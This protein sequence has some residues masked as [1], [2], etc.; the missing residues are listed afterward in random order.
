MEQGFVHLHVHSEYSLL[1]GANR[2][3]RLVQRAKELGMPALALTDHGNLFGAIEFYKKAKEVGIKPILGMEAYLAPTSRK[4]KEKGTFH[5]TLLAEN[6]EGFRNLMYLSTMSYLEGFYNRPRIDKE[7]LAE[8]GEGLIVLSGCLTSELAS[9]IRR[10]M[11][12]EAEKAL[13]EYLDIFGRDRFYIEI[14]RVMEE[15]DPV[16]RVLLEFARKH[17]LKVVATNDVHYLTPEEQR[18]QDVLICIQTG[19]RLNDPGRMGSMPN[20]YLKSPQEMWALFGNEVPEALTNTLEI[21]ERVDLELTLDPR[22]VHLPRFDIPEAYESDSDYL[23]HLAQEG[24]RRRFPQGVPPEYW[25]RLEHELRVIR[26]MGYS[27]YFLIIW[28]IVRNAKEKRGIRVGPGRGS[29]VGSLVL[30]ALGVTEIDPIR[31]GLLFERFLNPERVSPP[32]VDIDFS[33]V[34]RDKVIQYVRK[35]FGEDSVSQIITFGRMMARAVVRDVGRVLGIP[36]GETDRLVRLIP[37]V[38]GMTLEQ[39]LAE[40]RTLREL[41]ETTYA[42]L[43]ELARRIEGFVR[44]VSTHAAGVVIAPGKIWE[45]V[46]LY[47]SPDGTVSTQFDMKSLED[48]GLLKMD[49]LGLRTL[50]ILQKAEEMVRDRHDPTFS[51]SQIPLD[52]PQT[53]ALIGRGDTLGVFQLESRGFQELLRRMRPSTF[54]D[55]MAAVALYRPGPLQSGMV[56]DFIARKHGHRKIEYLLPQMEEVLKETYGAIVYQ[57]Q[58]MR[59]ASLIAGYSLGEADLLRRAMGK[60]KREIMEAQKE[61]FIR[62]AVE[63]G[64]KPEIAKKI[65]E[66]IEPFAGYGFNKSHAAGY[67]LISYQCAYLKA[68]YRSEFYAANMSAE[69]NAQNFHEK[70][71]QF[72]KEARAHDIPVLPPDINRS[73]REFKMEGAAIRFGLG[74]IKGVGKGAAQ[75]ILRVRKSGGPFQDFMDFLARIDTRKVNRKA[76][77]SLSKAG[78]FDTFHPNRKELLEALPKVFEQ[79]QKGRLMGAQNSLFGDMKPTFSIK[80]SGKPLD[81]ETLL[82]YEKESLGFFF[83]GHPLEQYREKIQQIPDRVYS[84]EL[85][86]L[87]DNTPVRLVGT[88]VKVEKRKSREGRRYATLT[89][90]DFEGEF[91]AMV[92]P[93]AFEE[94]E[95]LLKAEESYFVEGRVSVDAETSVAK[96]VVD[97]LIPLAELRLEPRRLVLRL[98]RSLLE[99][100]RVLDKLYDLLLMYPGRAEAVFVVLDNGKTFRFRSRSL[101]VEPQETLLQELREM[102]GEGNVE[103]KL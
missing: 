88:L 86:E 100:V 38:P 25:K 13:K 80:S 57:E 62:R 99:D 90:E 56:D 22:R 4:T 58:V 6:T 42:E 48:L 15:N 64:V 67:A 66:Q 47:R 44:N 1:D 98:S 89:F 23:A 102:L 52:D 93:N 45:Y 9:L 101:R 16:N 79:A 78:A 71:A 85:S 69:M 30:Y 68:H 97:H 7:L 34:D 49:F 54:E 65:F 51:L 60:K 27:G 73:D 83:S 63:R 24:L 21:A 95:P 32:D 84:S 77:E 81:R 74:A 12:R 40:N 11:P 94:L 10:G 35:R 20:I 41:A 96:V 2:I 36:Y 87:P 61:E 18:V 72:V 92:F 19:K 28:D 8:H 53:Y 50:T 33:D 59:L 82:S 37:S 46:P 39:A 91:Q 43:F 55:L 29:A 26:E 31:Y 14:M 3:D 17:D 75:A 103:V 76:V 70:I 5:I